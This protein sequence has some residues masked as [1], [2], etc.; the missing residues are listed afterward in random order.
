VPAWLK[1]LPPGKY[2]IK[3][4]LEKTK[5]IDKR[6]LTYQAVFQRLNFFNLEREQIPCGGLSSHFVTIYHWP[7]EEVF[8]R[9]K[10]VL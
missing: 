5:T 7:G 4:I 6:R 2:T 9:N 3:E 1:K 8:N 10:K